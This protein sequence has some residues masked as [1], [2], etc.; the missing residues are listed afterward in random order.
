MGQEEEGGG[1]GVRYTDLR[2]L[3]DGPS[4]VT[5]VAGGLAEVATGC[6]GDRNLFLYLPEAWN[7]G[8][9]NQNLF[10]VC[11]RPGLI[12]YILRAW[13]LTRV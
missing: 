5:E 4:W 3:G 9:E 2:G 10:F 6:V 11:K 8:T 12:Y 7:D 1:G 13:G